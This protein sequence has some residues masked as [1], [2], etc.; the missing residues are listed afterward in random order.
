MSSKDQMEC[1]HLFLFILQPDKIETRLRIFG[2]PK[3]REPCVD[4][5]FIDF[6]HYSSS[7]VWNVS[8]RNGFVD[9]SNSGLLPLKMHT[10]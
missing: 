7:W 5:W 9:V 4:F 1:F 6:F 10:I 3:G 8:E 2:V